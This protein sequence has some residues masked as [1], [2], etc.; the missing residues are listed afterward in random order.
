MPSAR[1]LVGGKQQLTEHY[2]GTTFKKEGL[3]AE[4]LARLVIGNK[5]I[6]HETT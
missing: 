3:R 4:I 6:D 5:V 1:V 2:G